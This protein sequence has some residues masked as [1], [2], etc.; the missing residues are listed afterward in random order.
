MRSIAD[1][2]PPVVEQDL[3]VVTPPDDRSVGVLAFT[4]LNVV[5]AGTDDDWVRDLLPGDDLAAPLAQPFVTA[6]AAVTGRVAGNLDTVLSAPAN[7]RAGGIELTELAE[8]REPLSPRLARALGQRVDVR[9]WR[10]PGGLLILGRGVAGRWEVSLEVDA[11]LR[12][13]GMGRGLLAAA[14]GL[15]PAGEHVWAQVAPGN[16]ASLRAALA[17]GFRP[18]GAEVL[19]R[20]PWPD[21]VGAGSFGWFA[22]E[23]D[24]DLLAS[25][26]DQA[27]MGDATDPA[28]ATELKTVDDD[29]ATNDHTVGPLSVLGDPATDQE[30]VN[31]RVH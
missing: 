30:S 8:F 3:V 13:F 22:R 12:G 27:G 15:V 17:A 4:G 1:G 6:L 26:L 24:A 9:A 11:P 25:R 31:W 29:L 21:Q 19:L 2:R 16:A 23:S 10:C 5:S 18:V 7:G 20:A 14:R 28:A